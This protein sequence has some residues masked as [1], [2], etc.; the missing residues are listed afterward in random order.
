MRDKSFSRT[1]VHNLRS[2]PSMR[3]IYSC[4]CCAYR[5]HGF[6]NDRL[7]P[8]TSISLVR[9]R[10]WISAFVIIVI[11]HSI[12][13]S[14]QQTIGM[15]QRY[16]F[17]ISQQRRRQVSSSM[18]KESI[19]SI[20]RDSDGFGIVDLVAA[21]LGHHEITH[22]WIPSAPFGNRMEIHAESNA[23]QYFTTRWYRTTGV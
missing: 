14:T 4:Y 20:S 23:V 2:L 10:F 5:F 12:S 6:S 13:D 8:S 15:L 9:R 1:L 18:G 11:E 16:P 7:L 3:W 17:G 22:G 19:R 21:R